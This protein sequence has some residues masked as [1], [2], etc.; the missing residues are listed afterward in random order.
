MSENNE[1]RDDIQVEKTPL[2]DQSIYKANKQNPTDYMWKIKMVNLALLVW[3]WLKACFRIVKEWF[4]GK[5]GTKADRWAMAVC[6][7]MSVTVWLFVMSTDD[8]GFEKQLT[9][10]EVNI[11]GSSVLSGGNMSIINGYGNN[12]NVT[13]K[14]KRGDIGSLSAEDLHMYVDVSGIIEPGRYTLPVL[15]DLPKNST[16][17]SIEPSNIAVNV[18]VNS[19]TMI[20]VKVGLDYSMDASYSISETVLSKESV[21]VSGP[22]SVLDTVKYAGVNF[23]VGRIDKSLTLVGAVQLFD[24]YGNVISNPYVKSNVSEITVLIK[25]TTTKSVPL[26]AK[27]SN[28]YSIM[29]FKPS[30]ITVEGDP[31]VLNDISEISVCTINFYD[32]DVGEHTVTINDLELP[33]GVYVAEASRDSLPVKIKIKRIY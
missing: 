30:T 15:L 4:T 20:D 26:V 9:G 8:P 14:G 27:I 12:V 24:E 7:V 5:R 11:E 23:N 28:N 33:D 19:S 21:L 2:Q 31:I 18:D 22:K 1:N 32:Y 10:V 17:I 3:S 25:V 13:L 6:L 29:E 16:L